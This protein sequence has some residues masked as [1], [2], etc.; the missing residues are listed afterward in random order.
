[1]ATLYGHASNTIVP[2]SDFQA[3][4]QENGGWKASQTF[5]IKKGDID[6]AGIKA[7]FPGGAT[8]VSIHPD[9]DLYFAFLRLS[10]IS[11]VQDI[12]GGWQDIRA[13]FVGFSDSTSTF[14]PPEPNTT[15]ATYSK[16]GALVDAPFLEHPKWKALSN[17]AKNRLGWLL[18][19]TAAINI[20]TGNY[21]RFDEDLKGVPI[22]GVIIDALEWTPAT[23]DELEF[24]KR[25]AQGRTTY[26]RATYQYFHRWQSNNGINESTMNDLSKI[27]V[28]TGSP[29]K[30]GTGRDWMLVGVDEEQ[31]GSGEFMFDNLL[32]YLLSDEGGHDSFLQS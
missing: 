21:M 12:P 18:D 4:Q 17:A 27:S 9:C 14:D 30:P 26:Q 8:L 7:K 15:R 28:P 23:G 13:E 10:H 25:I 19:G 32:T 1:M 5:R 16:R 22:L 3:N 20:E 31:S 29:P 6:N 2:Q 24:A 11:S